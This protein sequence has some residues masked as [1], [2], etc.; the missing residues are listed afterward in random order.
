MMACS[1]Q[2]RFAAM[3]QPIDQSGGKGLI[4]IQ[5]SGSAQQRGG[6][7]RSR[8]IQLHASNPMA[9][10]RRWISQVIASMAFMFLKSERHPRSW[11]TF[12]YLSSPE[13]S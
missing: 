6:S 5:E 3:H 13:Q 7:S 8:S 1:D 2:Y 10:I 12:G 9:P 4:D 11:A